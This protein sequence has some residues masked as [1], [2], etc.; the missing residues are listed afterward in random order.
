MIFIPDDPPAEVQVGQRLRRIRRE[1]TRRRE[2]IPNKLTSIGAEFVSVFCGGRLVPL[3]CENGG[4][5]RSEDYSAPNRRLQ[6]A[7][8]FLGT[9]G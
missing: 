6:V 3:K 8:D 9:V 7:T 2:N 4:G 1:K 5:A